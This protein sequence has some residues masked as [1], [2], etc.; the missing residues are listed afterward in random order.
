MATIA[1]DAI[2]CVRSYVGEPRVEHGLEASSATFLVG[3][4]LV[5]S[6]GYLA[7]ASSDPTMI[8]GIAAEP[9]HNIT[10]GTQTVAFYPL[11]GNI[12]EANLAQAA[13]STVSATTNLGTAYGIVARSTG[14]AHWVVDS[15][16]TSNTRCRPL[17]FAHPS[18]VTDTNA[19][20]EITFFNGND[21]LTV[22]G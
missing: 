15:S 16:D 22:A 6:S 3:A 18:V 12:F 17:R 7:G 4:P 5:W 1:I 20:I 14:T 11:A 21:A 8:V 9:G 13:S 19:R 2:R 10:A